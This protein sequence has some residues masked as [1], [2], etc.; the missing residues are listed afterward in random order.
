MRTTT[1][2]WAALALLAL[3][4]T[5]GPQALAQPADSASRKAARVLAEEGLSLFDQKDYAAALQRFDKADSLMAVPTV[6]LF[7]ARCLVQ[8]GRLVEASAR[9]LD[10]INTPLADDAPK[11]FK[12]A[13]SDAQQERAALLPRLAALA[14]TIEG[15]AEGATVLLDGKELD[16]ASLSDARPVDPG[17]HRVEGKRAGTTLTEEVTLAEG[18]TKAISFKLPKPRLPPPPPPSPPETSWMRTAGLIGLG[19]GGAGLA[20]WGVTGG[21]ALAQRG[22]LEENGCSDGRCPPWSRPGS[23]SALRVASMVGLYAGIGLA[24]TGATL[25]ILSPSPSNQPGT[26]ARIEP[27]IGVAS[28]GVR[29]AF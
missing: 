29:G 9:Y 10:V 3:G 24:A 2:R 19:A 23:Y 1:P 6:D 8:L 13:Q 25:F 4:L 28:G 5:L 11:T 27:W 14:V 17:T 20:V 26:A 12:T 21:I 22:T 18:E 7:A 15:G 16:A